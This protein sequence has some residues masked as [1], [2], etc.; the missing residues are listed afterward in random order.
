MG[1]KDIVGSRGYRRSRRFGGVLGHHGVGLHPARRGPLE[2]P[3]GIFP[4]SVLGL[5]LDRLLNLYI[6]IFLLDHAIPWLGLQELRKAARV[7]Q[8]PNGW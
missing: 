5:T 7:P 8:R 1:S 4:E 2:S 3:I 6:F